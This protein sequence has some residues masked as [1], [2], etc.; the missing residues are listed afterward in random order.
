MAVTADIT[1]PNIS[2]AI[3]SPYQ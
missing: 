1:L 3:I 2:C